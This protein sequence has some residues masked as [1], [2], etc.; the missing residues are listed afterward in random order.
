[1]QREVAVLIRDRR[2]QRIVYETRASYLNRWNSDAILGAMF[3]AAMKDFPT[4]ALSPR[5]VV[6]NLPRG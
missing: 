6:V 4:P 1:M 2:S 5:T 3:E